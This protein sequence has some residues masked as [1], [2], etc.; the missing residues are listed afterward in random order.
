MLLF[1]GAVEAAQLLNDSRVPSGDEINVCAGAVVGVTKNGETAAPADATA[2][3]LAPESDDMLAMCAVVVVVVMS[4]ASSN[5]NGAEGATT[6]VMKPQEGD[7]DLPTLLALPI[8]SVDSEA[9]SEVTLK[10]VSVVMFLL[11][12][13]KEAEDK[14]GCWSVLAPS[15]T[16]SSRA[17]GKTRSS[18]TA[19]A[20]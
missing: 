13:A 17:L 20:I 11:W 9:Y 19:F 10:S 7:G 15:C 1:P 12:Q 5:G 6:P 18:A 8:L 14:E 2:G 3:G 16:A 4:S